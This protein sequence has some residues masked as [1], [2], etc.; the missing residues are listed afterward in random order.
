MNLETKSFIQSQ[1]SKSTE[2]E[3]HDWMYDM[4]E[5]LEEEALARLRDA[6]DMSDCATDDEQCPLDTGESMN[7]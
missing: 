4:Y 5:Q 1:C 2:I 6:D 3:H 7:H